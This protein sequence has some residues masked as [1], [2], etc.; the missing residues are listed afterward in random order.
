M[1]P[2]PFDSWPYPGSPVWQDVSEAWIIR[3][4]AFSVAAS[5]AIRVLA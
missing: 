4:R 3:G 5:I 1:G 2:A